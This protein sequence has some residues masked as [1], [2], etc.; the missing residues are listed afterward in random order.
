MSTAN[1]SAGADREDG[2]KNITAIDR[3]AVLLTPSFHSIYTD[4]YD[5]Q[6]IQTA[7][8]SRRG[9]TLRRDQLRG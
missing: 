3:V 7:S 1:W 2:L 8:S 6:R 9:L 4:K 5:G